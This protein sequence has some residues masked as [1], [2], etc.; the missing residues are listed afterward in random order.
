MGKDTGI[1]K[2]A[3][4]GLAAGLVNGI[5]GSGGGTVLVP[6]LIFLMGIEDHKA[7]ATA[8]SIILPLSLISSFIYVRYDVVDPS[9]TLK[10]AAGSIMGALVGSCILNRFSVNALRKIFGFFMIIAAVR[11]VF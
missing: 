6:C 10:V 2:T 1:A 9:L 7:H 4:I 3:L 5:F 11:M 8:I